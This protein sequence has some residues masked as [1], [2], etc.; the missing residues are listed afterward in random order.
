MFRCECGKEFEK[1]NSF[2]AHKSNCKIHF[3]AKYGSD[4]VWNER[5]AK[6]AINSKKTLQENIAKKKQQELFIWI[7]EKHTCKTCGKVMTEKYGRGVFCSQSCANSHKNSGPVTN[8]TCEFC[9]KKFVKETTLSRHILYCDSNP[10][11]RPKA[12]PHKY[13]LDKEVDLYRVRVDNG[14]ELL[15]NTIADVEAYVETHTQCE[16]CGRTIEETVKWDS[17]NKAK[18]LCVDHD[19][20][21]M[22]FRG[23]L[24]QICNRQLGWYEKNKEAINNYLNRPF[25]L[26]SKKDPSE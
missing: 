24:C 3:R 1:P 6:R 9:G 18:R 22:Q 8:Y 4:D 21:S 12:T 25:P 13:K 14:N 23:I 2:N 19:H 20:E 15:V 11:R 7:E 17:P 10:N 16:I 26:K 5:Q